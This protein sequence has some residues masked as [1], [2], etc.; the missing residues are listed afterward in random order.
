MQDPNLALWGIRILG[1]LVVVVAVAVT[2]ISLT[3]IRNK[4][5]LLLLTFFHW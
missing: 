5:D 2:T 1:G 3:A 4:Q